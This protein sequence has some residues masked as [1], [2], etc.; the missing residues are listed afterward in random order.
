MCLEDEGNNADVFVGKGRFRFLPCVFRVYRSSKGWPCFSLCC[1]SAEAS[2]F[3][4]RELK[5][6]FEEP[7]F[8]VYSLEVDLREV[9]SRSPE[10][11]PPNDRNL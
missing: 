9:G 11:K 5:E 6:K 7:P 3:A 4:P 10:P 1:F 2:L 8:I